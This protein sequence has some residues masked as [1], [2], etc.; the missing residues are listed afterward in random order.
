MSET[1][2]LHVFDQV[3]RYIDALQAS[4]FSVCCARWRE[5]LGDQTWTTRLPVTIA[6]VVVFSKGHEPEQFH[7]Q[8]TLHS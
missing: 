4:G 7:V 3:Q 6:Y 5:K 8:R 1:E 2:R